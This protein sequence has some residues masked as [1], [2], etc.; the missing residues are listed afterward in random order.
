[1]TFDISRIAAKQKRAS[2]WANFIEREV[3]DPAVKSSVQKDLSEYRALLKRCWEKNEVTAADVAALENL[4][5]R[6][7]ELNEEARLAS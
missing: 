2:D 4:E 5:R 7:E 3:V 1:M 6:L